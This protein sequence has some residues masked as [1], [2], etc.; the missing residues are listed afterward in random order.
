M[1]AHLWSQVATGIHHANEKI[2]GVWL[3]KLH[4]QHRNDGFIPSSGQP[5]LTPNL[6]A[7]KARHTLEPLRSTRRST[8][9]PT[10]RS[11]A[12]RPRN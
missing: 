5:S 10:Q 12:L 6:T 8:C 3:Q 1:L 4:H 7:S 2:V 9:E 11:D